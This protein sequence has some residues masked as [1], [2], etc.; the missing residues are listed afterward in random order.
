MWYITDPGIRACLVNFGSEEWKKEKIYKR[1]KQLCNFIVL[2]KN[3]KN[4]LGGST[5]TG[6][7]TFA[8]DADFVNQNLQGS[9]S[10]LCTS[11]TQRK[12]AYE[13]TKL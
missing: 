1:E 7:N 8:D 3:Q 13:H 9:H 11:E 4:I 5:D 6:E 2:L 10:A 12:A